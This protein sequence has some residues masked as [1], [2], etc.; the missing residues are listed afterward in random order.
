MLIFRQIT[1]KNNQNRYLNLAWKDRKRR[2]RQTT[3]QRNK[4]TTIPI[5]GSMPPQ[6]F[7]LG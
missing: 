6:F 4:K 1:P 3:A 7:P 2:H 5:K